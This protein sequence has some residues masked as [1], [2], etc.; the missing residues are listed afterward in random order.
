[1]VQSRPAST[2]AF[3]PTKGFWAQ[4]TEGQTTT[5][6]GDEQTDGG[7]DGRTDDDN[8]DEDTDRG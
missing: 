3:T 2:W 8:D 4:I 5:D 6:D 7:T 1:M